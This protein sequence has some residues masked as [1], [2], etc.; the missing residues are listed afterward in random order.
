MIAFC[1]STACDVQIAVEAGKHERILASDA[2]NTR[3]EEFARSA[4]IIYATPESAA[5]AIQKLN[6]LRIYQ[7][8]KPKGEFC[9][10][11]CLT[12]MR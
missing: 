9:W 12:R 8:P 6:K 4:F 5:K 3:N 11:E 2:A 10:R 1:V 7:T